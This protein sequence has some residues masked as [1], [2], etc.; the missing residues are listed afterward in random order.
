MMDFLYYMFYCASGDDGTNSKHGKVAYGLELISTQLF[1][2]LIMILMGACNIR[3]N[4]FIIYVL[5]L[6]PIPFISYYLINGYYIKSG[7]YNKILETY[8]ATTN[9]Q[10]ILYKIITIFLF[11][12]SFVLLFV[13]G[14][15]MS[16]LLSLYE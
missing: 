7:R 9:R 5:I 16:Y 3:F 11:V 8:A 2:F 13:G 10:K 12:I 6:L 15:T 4:S 1:S 14:I